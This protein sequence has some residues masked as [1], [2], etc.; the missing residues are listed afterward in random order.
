MPTANVSIDSMFPPP[1]IKLECRQCKEIINNYSGRS[2]L[3]NLDPR[4]RWE[5]LYYQAKMN[6][7]GTSPEF[8]L[9]MDERE[10]TV[11]QFDGEEGKETRPI[12]TERE[13]EG[14]N[15]KKLQEIGRQYGLKGVRRRDL[16]LQILQ[17]QTAL[18]IKAQVEGMSEG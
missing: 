2:F 4:A 7:E 16:M 3:R 10:P 14:C 5:V 9:I 6:S 18:M 13:L 15:M 11:M 12:Y 8:T 1:E 17:K